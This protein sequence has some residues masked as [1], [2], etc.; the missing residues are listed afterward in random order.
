MFLYVRYR[1]IRTCLPNIEVEIVTFDV[2]ISLYDKS[3][4]RLKIKRS[5]ARLLW[6]DGAHSTGPLSSSRCFGGCRRCDDDDDDDDI[7]LKCG[8]NFVDSD[9]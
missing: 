2:D 1:Q 6:M 3:L 8:L 5:R 4:V 7:S 9:I